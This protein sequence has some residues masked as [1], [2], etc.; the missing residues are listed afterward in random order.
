MTDLDLARRAVACR[1]W[2]WMPGIATPEV[3]STCTDRGLPEWDAAR[4]LT[5]APCEEVCVCTVHGKVRD[6]HP[7]ALPDLTDPATLGCLLALVREAWA[8]ALVCVYP[9]HNGHRWELEIEAPGDEQS[10]SFFGATE[11]EAL[12]LALEAA[13]DR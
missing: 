4:V 12:V 5:S 2:R 10:R 1:G 8:E 11:A 6:L 7:G 13:H 3:L 9:A